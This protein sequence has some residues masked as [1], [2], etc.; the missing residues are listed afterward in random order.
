MFLFKFKILLF[1]VNTVLKMANTNIDDLTNALESTRV[2]LSGVSFAG[3]S[4]K[5]DTVE[6]GKVM[7][8]SA[9]SNLIIL[10]NI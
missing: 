6:D 9:L 4:L 10:K 3:K 5:L 7:L 8:N 1:S 2:S